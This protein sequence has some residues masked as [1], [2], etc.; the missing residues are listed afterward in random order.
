MNIDL[1]PSL[2]DIL[3]NE[4]EDTEEITPAQL[5]EIVEEAW[6]NEKFAPEILPQKIDYIECLLS[7]ISAMQQNLESVEYSDIKKG[8]HQLEV[9]RLKY[10]T[11]SYLRI[12][13]NKIENHTE[14]LLKQEDERINNDLEP[15]LSPA[16][17]EFARNFKKGIDDHFNK[18]L[19]DFPNFIKDELKN[20]ISQPN[21]HTFVF[22][23]SKKDVENIEVDEDETVYV[24]QGSQMITSYSSIANLV[25]NGD[26]HLI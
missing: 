2:A 19:D 20:H 16:E 11:S 4:D 18:V 3:E 23:K 22:S 26:V 25:K 21:L 10:L 5:I 1:D 15:Y 8:I 13:L 9:D 24:N 17:L 6:L 7:Q 12:R 14:H